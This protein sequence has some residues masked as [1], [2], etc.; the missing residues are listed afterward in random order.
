MT[1]DVRKT[2][3]GAEA[4]AAWVR[5]VGQDRVV[6]ATG[7]SQATVS[8]NARGI[9]PPDWQGRDAYRRA[10][11][12]PVEAWDMETSVPDEHDAASSP[13]A[14]DEANISASPSEAPGPRR[15]PEVHP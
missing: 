10:R 9:T 13:P 2:N 8:R 14:E 3:L 6:A 12:I 1:S 11:G 7:R 4:L 15:A 5:E